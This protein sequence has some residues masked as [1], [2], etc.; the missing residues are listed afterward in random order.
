MDM[1]SIA[2]AITGIRFAKDTVQTFVDYKVEEG[3]QAKVSAVLEKLAIA[4]ES[5][6]DVR[7]ELFRLQSDNEQLRQDL[8]SRDDWDARKA[9][10]QLERTETG[11]MVWGSTFE[12]KH[13]VCPVCFERREAHMLQPRGTILDCPA[14]KASYQARIVRDTPMRVER[15]I[16]DFNVWGDR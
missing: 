15:A 16:T 14:C 1:T 2:A 6:F 10:Y 11:V 9:R 13:F 4:Q 7:D 12:P 8:K 3:S 5:L